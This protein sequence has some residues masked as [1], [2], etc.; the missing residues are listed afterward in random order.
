MFGINRNKQPPIR[1]LIGEGTVIEGEVR[2][3]DGLRID[4]EVLGDV[5]ATGAGRSLLV[6]GEK[7]SITGRVHAAHVI[8]NGTVR[9]PLECEQLL[10]LQP[11]AR[12]EGDVR[13]LTLEMHQGA[14]VHGELRPL[15]A[16]VEQEMPALKLA[17]NNG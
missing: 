13:Y 8:V 3:S 6:I 15:D 9:G 12:I 4:G 11:K 17:S 14:Q 1:T 5:I 16:P 2:F 7:A 10:E